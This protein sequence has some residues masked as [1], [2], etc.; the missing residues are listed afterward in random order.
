MSISSKLTDRPE[1]GRSVSFTACV[2]VAEML[3]LLSLSPA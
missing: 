1:Q 3:P 2:A